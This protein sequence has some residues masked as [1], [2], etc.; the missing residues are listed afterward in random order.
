MDSQPA[1]LNG[2][3]YGNMGFVPAFFPFCDC[4]NSFCPA[5]GQDPGDVIFFTRNAFIALFSYVVTNHQFRNFSIY[6]AKTVE[7]TKI[8]SRIA[9]KAE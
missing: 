9:A 5:G 1:Y 3:F 6:L 4:D 7:W 2:N 8:Y